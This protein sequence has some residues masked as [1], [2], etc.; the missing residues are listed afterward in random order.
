MVDCHLHTA[1]FSG[2]ASATLDGYLARAR[3]LGLGW[4]ATTEHVDFCPSDSC[5]GHYDATQHRALYARVRAQRARQRAPLKAP[6]VGIGVEVDYQ[7]PYADEARHFVEHATY[8]YVLGSVHYVQGELI[9][10]R[11][12]Y[13]RSEREAF[14]AYFEEALR[15]VRSGLFD[16]LGHLDI[17]KRCGVQHYGPFGPHR[18]GDEIDALLRACVETGTGIEINTSGYRGPPQEPFPALP[19]LRRY[20]ALGGEVLTIGS[21]AHC[22]ADLGRDADRAL[23]LARAAG[24]RAITIFVDR[25][26]VWL[27]VD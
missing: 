20:R 13:R 27:P 25:Q 7:T 14:V 16:V 1:A 4:I 8:D 26:P 6:G 9:F 24:F 22:V 3:A 11:G 23:D 21:D 5:Y 17:V 19:V 2:D 15:A 12:F 18:Y 10:D